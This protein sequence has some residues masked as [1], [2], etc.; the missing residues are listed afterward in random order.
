M[1]EDCKTYFLRRGSTELACPLTVYRPWTTDKVQLR[2]IYE[3][4]KYL[5]RSH[6]LRRLGFGIC[7]T[8]AFA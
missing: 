7:Y 2:N 5:T 8:V 1:I 4:E 3:D 6:A